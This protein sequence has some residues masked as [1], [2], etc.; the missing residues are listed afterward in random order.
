MASLLDEWLA[1]RSLGRPRQ[2]L[3]HHTDQRMGG[4]TLW[5]LGIEI[6]NPR[7]SLLLPGEAGMVPSSP[8]QPRPAE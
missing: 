2:S 7:T 4:W 1:R 5:A 8:I 6:A 3:L